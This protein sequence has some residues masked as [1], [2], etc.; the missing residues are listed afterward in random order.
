MFDS[1]AFI[2]FARSEPIMKAPKAGEK[3]TL[4]ANKTIP[5]Q[6]PRLTMSI[7][8]SLRFF[9]VL[10]RSVG[11]KNIPATN[12]SMRKKRSCKTDKR[13]ASPSN[14]LVTEIVE[15][16]TRRI[17]GARSSMIRTPKTKDAKFLPF[18]FAPLMYAG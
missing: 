11:I 10:S 8:S 17:I 1:S 18:D 6:S 3:P 16:I 15:R 2:S 5:R 7:V 13:S 14:C 9:L 4:S 12:Q